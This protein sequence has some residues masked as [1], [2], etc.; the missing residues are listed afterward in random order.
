M[1]ITTTLVT[2]ESVLELFEL[3]FNDLLFKAATIHRENFN[4]NEIQVSTLLSIK[5]GGCS[6]DCGYCS[7]SAHYDTGLEKEEVL[8]KTVVI[9]AAK[10]AKE[11]GSSRFCMGAAWRAL[12]DKELDRVAELVH[13]VKAI[14]METC[15]TL[16]MITAEQADRLHKA[17]LDYYNHNLD[18]SEQH[19][20][21][22]VSTHSYQDRLDTINTVQKAGLKVC[23]GGIL[24]IGEQRHDRA[25]MLATLASLSQPP[26]SVPINELVPIPGTPQE[27]QGRVEPLE[28]LRTVAVARAVL[29]K[30]WIRLSAG[31]ES[32]SSELQAMCFFAGANSIFSGEKLLTAPGAREEQD[33]KLFAMLGVVAV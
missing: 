16:G 27:G 7:Q 9:N 18:T 6:E 24:G 32:M 20:E 15:L 2:T 17:G 23:S 22:I 11:S 3:P 21:N 33:G 13:E 19:Y 14:G 26:D 10:E 30:S 1:P 28:F 4:H 5:T 12:P 25:A 8:D 29:P 31:R